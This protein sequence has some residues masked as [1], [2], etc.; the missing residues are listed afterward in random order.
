MDLFATSAREEAAIV[1]NRSSALY[2][3]VLRG[4]A[5]ERVLY[6]IKDDER[7]V[8]VAMLQKASGYCDLRQLYN[9]LV[10]VLLMKVE[11]PGEGDVCGSMA[12]RGEEVEKTAGA[13]SS[14]EGGIDERGLG[15]VEE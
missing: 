11:M 6:A 7:D 13:E 5:F 10:S 9:F 14:E 2:P 8:W 1:A 15:I 12:G 4:R 3:L